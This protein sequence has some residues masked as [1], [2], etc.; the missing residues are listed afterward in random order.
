MIRHNHCRGLSLSRLVVALAFIGRL[1]AGTVTLTPNPPAAQLG[2]I[3]TLSATVTPAATGKVTFYDGT[4]ILGIATLSN[5]VA[6]LATTALPSGRRSVRAYYGGDAGNPAAGSATLPLQ[7]TSAPSGGFLAPVKYSTD[8]TPAAVNAMVVA[9]FNGDLKADLAVANTD[10]G[11]IGILLGNGDGTF[12]APTRVPAGIS[13]NLIVVGDWNMDGK[14]DL[15]VLNASSRNLTI[16]AGNGDGTF[17]P[18]TPIA[19]SANPVFLAVADFNGDGKPDLAVNMNG[20]QILLGRGDGTFQFTSPV[21]LV[22][23]GPSRIVAGDFNGDGKADLAFNGG[24]SGQ[25]GIALGI[26][27]GTFGPVSYIASEFPSLITVGDFNNDGKLDLALESLGTDNSSTEMLLGN[28]DGTFQEAILVGGSFYAT[29]TAD[30]FGDGKLDLVGAEGY[31]LTVS[32]NRQLF[33]IGLNSDLTSRAGSFSIGAVASA[34]VVG[35]F[36]GDGKT[37]AIAANTDA[38]GTVS[39]LLGGALPDLTVSITQTNGLTQGQVGYYRLTVTNAGNAPSSG[40]VTLTDHSDE[41]TTPTSISG[42]GWSCTL[43]TLAS[44]CSRSD[45]LAAGASYPPVYLTVTVGANVNGF[46]SNSAEVS[47]GSENNVVGY[48]LSTA[49]IRF[50]TNVTLTATPNP[51]ALGQAATLT[52]LVTNGTGIVTF[53]DGITILGVSAISSGRA[54]LTTSLLPSGAHSLTARYGGD[55][56]YGIATSPPLLQTVNASAANGLTSA[57]SFTIG[58]PATALAAAD[59]NRDGKLD[60]LTTNTYDASVLLGNGDGT[61]QSARTYGGQGTLGVDLATVGD[62]NGDGKPDLAIAYDSGTN[63]LAILLGN[64][65]G[66]FQSPVFVSSSPGGSNLGWLGLRTAD[67]NQ[68]GIADLALMGLSGVRVFLGNGDGTFQAPLSLGP[69][70]FSPRVWDVADF[71]NDGIPDMIQGI[72]VFLGIGDGTFKTAILNTGASLTFVTGDYNGDGKT[73]VAQVSPAGVD[74]LLGNGDGT[75]QTAVASTFAPALPQPYSTAVPGDFNGDGKLDIAYRPATAAGG[76]SNRVTL[77]FGRGDG[78]FNSTATVPTDGFA[79][80]IALGDFNGDG[81]PDFVVSNSD[82]QSINVFLGGAVSGFAI[83]VSHTGNFT[84][85]SAGSYLITASNGGYAASSGGVTVTDTLPVGLTATAMSGAGWNCAVA[86]ATC[87]RSDALAA[88]AS[89]PSITLNVNVAGNLTASTV[90][91]QASVLYNSTSISATDPT[92]LVSLAVGAPVPV[93]P[94]AGQIGVA[95]GTSLTWNAGA[96]ATSYDVYFGTLSIPPFVANTAAT[97]YTPAAAL[98]A[99][100][101]YYWRIVSRNPGGSASGPTQSF[102][103]AGTAPVFSRIGVFRNGTWA[104]DNG[105]LNWDGPAID[106]L[107]SFGLPGDIP[108]IGDW[109]GSGKTKIGVYRSGEWFLDTNGN[110][111]YD[112]GVDQHGFFGGSPGDIPVVGDWDGT[113]K[114]KV[115]VFRRGAWVLDMNGNLQFDASDRIGSFGAPND[116]PVVGDWTGDKKSKVGVYRQGVWLLDTNGNTNWDPGVDLIG[117]FGAPTDVIVLGDWTGSGTTKVGV[118]RNGA[119]VLDMN[120]NANWDPGVDLVGSFGGGPTDKPVVGDWTGG[121]KAKIGIYRDGVWIVDL[122]GTALYNPG[123]VNIGSFGIPNDVPLTGKWA[124]P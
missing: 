93:S 36:N 81:V 62:F 32:P 45:P 112:A 94:T 28:G 46:V 58:V 68:D 88:G 86:T 116:I 27:D 65:D 69:V 55:S 83:S 120:G 73:D 23:V 66:T 103:T 101:V 3:V 117:S 26:G 75:L 60:L 6:T 39:V 59:F 42:I 104:L 110:G 92:I 85:G 44:T 96:G 2:Q 107:T 11:N 8:A 30:V 4:T 16:Y 47:V 98:T 15:A 5:S 61:F 115:G 35:D 37:D 76:P 19:F 90:N 12:R 24:T 64:G 113:G 119:W 54:V 80:G 72:Y 34:V 63:S 124:K 123:T 20:I 87:T 7:V 33:V 106:L 22:S 99:G 29:T 25:L 52:A 122:S 10:N 9:D 1:N 77:V 102:T 67:F 48:G 74:T 56:S 31:G 109:D 50:P 38:S 79:G 118:Y 97:S 51:S 49:R 95:V 57:H 17:Q 43:S 70:T 84:I 108:V 41:G 121:G 14:Q 114:T 71:N 78:M 13:P 105:N 91:N 89:Y 40:V 21:S 82:T 111:V 18:G 100:T 53:Y